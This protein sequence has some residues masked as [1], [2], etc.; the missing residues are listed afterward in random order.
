VAAVALFTLGVPDWGEVDWG[1][2]AGQE[3]E[4]IEQTFDV[5][6]APSLQI[7]NFSGSV[8][9]RAGEGDTIQVVATKRVRRRSDL[10]RIKIDIDERG[11]GLVIK[12]T[13]PRSLMSASVELEITTPAGTR[14]DAHTGSGSVTVQ[15][16]NGDARLD[17]GSGSVDVHDLSGDVE[18]DTGSGSVKIE[19][20]TGEIDAHSGSGSIDVRGARGLVRLRTGSGNIEY[21]GTPQGDC[22]FETGSGRI[23]LMLPA[24]LN[25]EVDLDT[26]SG[27]IDVDFDVDGRVTKRKVEGDIGDGSEGSIYAHTGSGSIDLIRR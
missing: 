4:R 12:T 11:G 17:T 19:D 18:I 9:V 22:R 2:V 23:T 8:T 3:R 21:Q 5:G 26:N 10:E 25:M 27:D 7:D 24:D 14:L 20:V 13:K 15:G 1:E 6:D 16:L